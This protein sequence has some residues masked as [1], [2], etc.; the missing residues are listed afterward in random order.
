MDQ[1]RFWDSLV[2]DQIGR[3][4]FSIQM[5]SML[6]LRVVYKKFN[7]SLGK[8]RYMKETISNGLIS[9]WASSGEGSH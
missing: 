9:A 5:S 2:I 4:S 3:Y 6:E 8:K 7:M 1:L